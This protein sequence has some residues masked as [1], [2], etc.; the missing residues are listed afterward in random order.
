MKEATQIQLDEIC[1]QLKG[2]GD[3]LIS[4]RRSL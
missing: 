4:L 1:S 3:K 2:Y